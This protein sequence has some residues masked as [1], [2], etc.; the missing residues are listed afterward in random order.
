MDE[1]GGENDLYTV[2]LMGKHDPTSGAQEFTEQI[3][4]CLRIAVNAA[5][6]TKIVQTYFV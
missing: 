6:A 1:R 2:C 3:N 5:M 4:R